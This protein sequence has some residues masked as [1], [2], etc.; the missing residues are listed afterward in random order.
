MWMHYDLML[1]RAISYTILYFRFN[2]DYI[3]HRNAVRVALCRAKQLIPITVVQT[4]QTYGCGGARIHYYMEYFMWLYGYW[5]VV[6]CRD[7][8]FISVGLNITSYTRST[9][10]RYNYKIS[11]AFICHLHW[12]PCESTNCIKFYQKMFWRT[13]VV[14]SFSIGMPYSQLS[15]T[16]IIHEDFGTRKGYLS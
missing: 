5:V 12:C 6:Y 1:T 8:E 15:N 7:I 16:G 10:Y 11:F 9:K 4:K 13:K 14:Y 3:M 2:L